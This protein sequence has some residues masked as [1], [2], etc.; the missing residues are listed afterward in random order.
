MK[1]IV[2]FLKDR[3]GVSPVIGVILMV[4]ITVVMAAVIAAW[5]YGHGMPK[6]VPD[7]AA[8]LKDDPKVTLVSANVSQS[9]AM[10]A[11]DA[12]PNIF[13]SELRCV[14]TYFDTATPSL[15]HSMSLDGANWVDQTAK[16]MSTTGIVGSADAITL[17]WRD[18]DGTADISPGDRL[19][20]IEGSATAGEVKANTDFMVK[21][22]HKG[23][24]SVLVSQTIKV[25]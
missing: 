15:E 1:N 3:R 20:F 21:L 22:I 5:V 2:K 18:S 24:E 23:S 14:V 10:L 4:A 6:S 19:D 25:R 13:P 9:V 7:M 17:T 16:Y 11:I 12:G 8:T